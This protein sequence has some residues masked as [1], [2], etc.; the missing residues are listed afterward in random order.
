MYTDLADKLPLNT[1]EIYGIR[2]DSAAPNEWFCIAMEDLTI[3]SNPLNQI[4]GI[5]WDDQKAMVE[6][7]ANFN[8]QFYKSPILDAEWLNTAT[9]TKPY[10]PWFGEWMDGLE[11]DSSCWEHCKRMTQEKYAAIKHIPMGENPS[12]AAAFDICTGPKRAA[13]F[14]AFY[15]RLASRPPNPPTR[16]ATMCS[17]ARRATASR[18][19]TGRCRLKAR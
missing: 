5:T 2:R 13:I 10:N 18:L 19:S 14:K 8:A 12:L 1:P 7:I 9:K 6:V 15:E 16:A 4:E 3:H 11:A 17:R